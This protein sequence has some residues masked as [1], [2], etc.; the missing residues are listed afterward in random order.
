MA[1]AWAHLHDA[2]VDDALDPIVTLH[3]VS[4]PDLDDLVLRDGR[5]DGVDE[6]IQGVTSP[7]EDV[8]AWKYQIKA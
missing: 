3:T 6:F 1:S 8:L 2:L 4:H 7:S 5:G